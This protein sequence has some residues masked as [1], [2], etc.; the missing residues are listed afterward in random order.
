MLHQHILAGHAEIG[1]AVFD[2]GGYVRGTDNHQFDVITVG[3]EDQF[4]TGLRVV[5]GHDP[6]VG[7]QRQGFF[8]D[9]PL[10]EGDSQAIRHGITSIR[11]AFW[12][13]MSGMRRIRAPNWVS[14]SSIHS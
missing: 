3:V 7:Q 14:F 5:L 9:P 11:V 2:V 13:F 10:G 8:E 6:G 4:A 12:K 1:R